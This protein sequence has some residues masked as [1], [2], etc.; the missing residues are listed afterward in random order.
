MDDDPERQ[1]GP[2]HAAT[3]GDGSFLIVIPA[4][5]AARTIG[6]VLKGLADLGDH[7]LVIDDGSD[8]GTGDI[9]RHTGFAV[10]RHSDNI[11]VGGALKTA[12]RWALDRGHETL[13]TID[14]DGQHDPRLIGSFLRSLDGYDL[15]VGNRFSDRLERFNDS[16]IGAN[17][18]AA[19]IVNDAFG[20]TFTDIACGYRAFRCERWILDIAADRYGFLYEHLLQVVA[21]GGR[22][23]TLPIPLVYEPSI[24]WASRTVEIEG[25]LTALLRRELPEPT[26]SKVERTLEALQRGEDFVYEIGGHTFY[27]F[28]VGRELYLIQT[29]MKEA[30]RTLE[31]FRK[32]L[33]EDP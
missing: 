16:K 18:L 6:D 12:I 29:D 27:C 13:V 11:G 32:P 22:I 5:N 19:L 10:L 4:Y 15:V 25:F 7:V 31:R 33:P 3:V 17:L 23:E 21:R 24:P 8:D 9:V 2:P 26:V 30:V 28:A 1:I 20:T 14:A